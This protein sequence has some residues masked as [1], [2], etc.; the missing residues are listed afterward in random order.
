[1]Q[2]KYGI[3]LL[4]FWSI[5]QM[6]EMRTQIADQPAQLLRLFEDSPRYEIERAAQPPVASAT[7][8]PRSSCAACTAPPSS[9]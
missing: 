3:G 1:M 9:T 6:L 5:G 8:T 2:G 7:A 4:G